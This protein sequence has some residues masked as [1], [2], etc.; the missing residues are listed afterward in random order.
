[1]VLAVLLV[2]CC[3]SDGDFEFGGA[4]WGCLRVGL[5]PL[6]ACDGADT[7]AALFTPCLSSLA[8]ACAPACAAVR[9]LGPLAFSPMRDCH[10]FRSFKR[11]S[12]SPESKAD[13]A[14]IASRLQARIS[15]E[16][17]IIKG[18]AARKTERNQKEKKKENRKK[19]LCRAQ[20]CSSVSSI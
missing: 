10:I 4:E 8:W 17:H 5:L 20:T 18:E 1:M 2:A 15:R 12:S 3:S 13:N 11:D 7:V 14:C 16:L 6:P 19:E 9:L